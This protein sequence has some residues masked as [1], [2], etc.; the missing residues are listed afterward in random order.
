MILEGRGINIYKEI[1]IYHY[2]KG[3]YPIGC[4]H[5]LSGL[6]RQSGFPLTPL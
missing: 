1:Y 6:N 2:T 5:T 3:T 4:K